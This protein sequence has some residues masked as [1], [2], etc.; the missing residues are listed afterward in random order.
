MSLGADAVEL[1]VPAV[2][3]EVDAVTLQLDSDSSSILC[4]ACLLYDSDGVCEKVVHY[5]DRVYKNQADSYTGGVVLHS[6]D[7]KVPANI[8]QMYLTLCSCGPANLSGFANPSISLYDQA[9]PSANLLEYTINQAGES[10]SC[11]MARL[12]RRAEWR[13]EKAVRVA[14]MLRQ[15]GMPFLCIDICL[16][17]A[18]DQVWS[19]QAL[20]TQEW[21]LTRK[22]CGNY[23]PA[24]RLIEE[25]LCK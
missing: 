3:D 6:G 2:M 4:G 1:D 11:V 17:M 20:G 16:T 21:H 5:S 7:T 22:I 14:W 13:K 9:E 19:V 8:S 23:G 15:K 12:V 10:C 25:M 24:Q 18:A